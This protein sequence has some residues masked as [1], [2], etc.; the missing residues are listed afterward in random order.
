MNPLLSPSKNKHGAVPFQDIRPE[1]FLP[2]L[3]AAIERGQK[4]L[5]V[6]RESKPGFDTTI[7]GLESASEDLEFV[8]LVFSNL[9][10]ADGT[11]DL[12][13]LAAEIGPKVASFANDILLDPQIFSAIQTVYKDREKFNL[14]HEQKFL[15]EKLYRDFRRSGAELSDA[16]KNQ[17]R[18]LDERLSQLG[19]KFRE[20]VLKATNAFELWL[21]TEDDLKGLPESARA[22]A[23]D[24][25]TEKGRPDAWLV[26]LQTPSFISFM[27]FSER[28]DLREKVFRAAGQ[29]AF[30]DKFDNQ[31]TVL[32]TVRLMTERAQILGNKNYAEWALETRMA[33]SPDTVMNFLNKMLKV[34][35]PAADRDLKELQDFTSE[36]GGPNPL[37]PWDFHFYSERLKEKRYAFNEE[38]L[39]PYFK[40]ENVLNGVFELARRLFGLKFTE[41]REY[42]VYHSDVRVFEVTREGSGDY[43]GLFYADFFPRA[44]KSGGAWMT[45][46]FDQGRF[47]GKDIRPHISIV[48]NFTKPTG[49]TPSLLTFDEVLTLFHEFGHALHGLLSKVEF[50]ALAGTN[51]YLDFVELPSQILENWAEEEE[52]LKVYARHYK[53]GEVLPHEML[54]KLKKAQLF[55]AGYA[56]LRQ[57]RFAFLDMAWFTEPLDKQKDVDAFE[58]QVVKSLNVFPEV[59]NTNSSCSFAHIFGGGYASGYYSYKWAEALDAD[60]FEFFKEKGIFD[61]ETARQFE[62]CILSKGGSEHPM[63]LYEKF[64]GR[65]PD[66]EALLR[67]DG[68]IN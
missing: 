13:K 67:R 37:Q 63:K 52:F 42:P 41:S 25:A 15:V 36:V 6:I 58:K 65:K 44:T 40:L 3:E 57:L 23:K 9:L 60:A 5:G 29:R 10:V 38:D 55:Q 53:T 33:E 45:T 4:N 22:A 48:C 50:R 51:V 14:T 1:H 62:E 46:Y 16:K 59:P 7:R 17:V 68:L 27:R 21:T 26:T 34:V 61:R 47:R 39:K 12:Q 18:A 64:R 20:N 49:E 32:E 35:K 2:A 24:A 43:V 54:T 56:A 11:E 66:P 28:R 31:S 8:N 19:P 30:N